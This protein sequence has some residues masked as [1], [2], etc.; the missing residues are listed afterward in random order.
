MASFQTRRQCWRPREGGSQQD[1]SQQDGG[2]QRQSEVSSIENRPLSMAATVSI[3]CRQASA[4]LMYI[5][6][7][8]MCSSH[9]Y[10]RSISFFCHFICTLRRKNQ[11][12]MVKMLPTDMISS[13]KVLSSHSNRSSRKHSFVHLFTSLF[14][15]NK[16]P[17]ATC[18]G[19]RIN[20]TLSTWIW[21]VTFLSVLRRSHVS[22]VCL[23]SCRFCHHASL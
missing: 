7:L 14:F 15:S 2:Q 1:G 18:H 23:L 5:P 3:F 20:C 8:K 4:A 13:T 16:S 6:T 22:V 9:H 19:K 17:W 21:V 11:I 12:L 10:A